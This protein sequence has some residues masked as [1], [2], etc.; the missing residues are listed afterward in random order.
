MRQTRIPCVIMRGGSSRGPYFLESDLPSDTATRDAVL[1]AAMGSGH[2]LQVDG[3]GGANTL[4]SKVA[5]VAP[6]RE[7]GVDVDYLFAQVD[8]LKSIVDTRPNCGNM[9]AGVGPFAIEAGILRPQG[10]TTLVRI[11]NRNTSALIEALIQTP[12]GEVT[13]DGDAAIPGVPGTAAPIM[14][15]FRQVAGAK[16]GKLF[17]TGQRREM[18]DGIE[19]SLVDC[20]MPMMLL[21]AADVGTSAEAAPADIDGDTALL[22]RIEKLRMEAGRRMGF[23]D[24][25][26]SVVPKVGLV[27]P[28]QGA[29]FAVRYLTPH[30]VHKALA[31]TGAI[32]LAAASRVPGTVVPQVA[33]ETVYIRHPGGV[34]DVPIA[35]NGEEDVAWAGMLRTAR[36]IMEGTLLVPGRIWTG[37]AP[38]RLAAE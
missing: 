7:E 19:V 23:G 29:D 6:S 25:T 10:E 21:R 38:A 36:R 4:T 30:A 34:L 9:L 37:T 27:G 17:P 14:L 20:A 3:I 5:I 12:G 32:C 22:A 28:T 8:V 24:V 15:R 13:Y 1:L 2:Q 11:R 33:G 18:I 31:V 16:T 26:D 35:M